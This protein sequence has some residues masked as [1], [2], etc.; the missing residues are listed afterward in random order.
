MQC[1][2]DMCFAEAATG[3]D[4][5]GFHSPIYMTDMRTAEIRTFITGATR[6][7]D[8]DKFDYEGFLCPEVLTRYAEYMHQ[9]RK[10]SDGNLR[11][12]DN[13]QKGIPKSQY[14]KSMFRHF[15]AIWRTYRRGEET[16]QDDLCAL[17]FN[18]MGYLHEDIKDRAL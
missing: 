6:D 15:M 8:T 12:S 7:S 18:V 1:K 4:V 16:N 3:H 10:Q 11:D 5:C 2:H 13:W 14:M 9:H 17:A